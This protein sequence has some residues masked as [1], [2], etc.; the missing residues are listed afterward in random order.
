MECREQFILGVKC[1][2]SSPLLLCVETTQILLC[3]PKIGA[4]SA[5]FLLLSL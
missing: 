1:S 5:C 2:L 4:L 3:Y